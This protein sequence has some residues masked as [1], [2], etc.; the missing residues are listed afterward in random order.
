MSVLRALSKRPRVQSWS[1][2]TIKGKGVD[3][4]PV[5]VGLCGVIPLPNAPGLGFELNRDA[6][7]R[8]E[9]AAAKIDVGADTRA[10]RPRI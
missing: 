6:L 3:D 10:Q 5:G 4:Y 1:T 7:Q 8:F 2:Q 9:E